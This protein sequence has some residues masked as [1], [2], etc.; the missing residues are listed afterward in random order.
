MP[1]PFSRRYFWRY[2]APFKDDWRAGTCDLLSYLPN[3]PALQQNQQPLLT[4]TA[5]PGAAANSSCN[6]QNSFTLHRCLVDS[7]SKVGVVWA[8]YARYACYILSCL[9]EK[10]NRWNHRTTAAPR[11]DTVA[12]GL[13][14]ITEIA[15]E[16]LHLRAD[17]SG[18]RNDNRPDNDNGNA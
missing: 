7:P 12:P 5:R 3:L 9:L 8:R 13:S 4:R 16:P 1:V 2:L 14:E 17:I 11:A 15:V 18:H 10:Q 6:L